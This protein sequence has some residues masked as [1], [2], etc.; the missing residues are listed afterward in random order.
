M[1]LLLAP[2]SPLGIEPY[3]SLCIL[4]ENKVRPA[5]VGYIGASQLDGGYRVDKR[6]VMP[7]ATG[8]GLRSRIG[9]A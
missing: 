7:R 2:R 4:Y 8:L 1:P 9:P 6:E 5:P 3:S